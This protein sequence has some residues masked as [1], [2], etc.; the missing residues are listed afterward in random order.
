MSIGSVIG[1]WLGALFTLMI[2]SF[3]Y[4]DNP[5]YKLAEHIFLGISLGYSWCFAFWN[6]IMPN[7][8]DP[9]RGDD[10]NLWVL[11]PIVLGIFI[12]LRVIP[13]LSWLSR[14]SFAV[15]I[16]G[17]AGLAI[18]TEFA[19][20]FLPQIVSTMN[21]LWPPGGAAS[22]G[23]IGPAVI[24]LLTQLFLL[25]GVFSTVVFFFFSLEHKGVVGKISRIGVLFIMVSFGAAF[26]YT[27]MGRISLLIGRFQF[28][29]YDWWQTAIMGGG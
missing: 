5:V 18:P 11:I 22:I 9:L 16:G 13:K 14:Y 6:N 4:K 20:R 28:L 19:G 21:P 3:L 25:V 15:L 17:F 8:V 29:I 7:A 26:G 2:F 27:V 24:L 12:V 1:I 23:G 10:P